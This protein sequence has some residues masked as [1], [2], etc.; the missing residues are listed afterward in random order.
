MSTQRT[1]LGTC[2]FCEASISPGYPLIEYETEDGTVI[3]AEC[4]DCLDVIYSE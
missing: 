3:Y 2:P 1:P 4:P